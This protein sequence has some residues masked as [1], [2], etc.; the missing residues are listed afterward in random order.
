MARRLHS[1]LRPQSVVLVGATERSNWSN[2]VVGNLRTCGYSGQLFLVNPRGGTAYGLPVHRMV[3]EIQEPVDLAYL[4]VP[5]AAM[6]EAL[7]DLAAAGIT[8]AIVLTSGFAE[9]GEEGAR[10]QEALRDK[11]NAHGVSLIGPNCLGFINQVDNIPLW[12]IALPSPMIRGTLAIVSQSGATAALMSFFAAQQGIGFSHLVSTGNEVDVDIAAVVDYLVDDPDTRAIALFVET[13][14]HPRLL[15]AAAERAHAAKKPIIVMKIGASEIT[16]KSAQAHTG[17]LV[18]DDRVFD[19][20]CKK[21]GLIRVQSIEDAIFTAETITKLGVI[22]GKLGFASMSGGFCEIAADRAHGEGVP[23]ATLAAGTVGRLKN[24][25]PGFGTPHNPLDTTGAVMLDPSIM[26]RSLDALADDPEVGVIAV[27]YDVPTNEGED[28]PFRRAVVTEV[29]DT[30]HRS[31]LPSVLFSYTM[32]PIND[33]ARALLGT[34]GPQA[35][36][37]ACGAHHGLTALRG[38]FGWSD[39]IRRPRVAP[40]EVARSR[41]RPVTEHQTLD[42]LA[43]AGVPVI[44]R[45]VADSA[46]SA[47]DAAGRCGYPVVLK[48]ASADIP[49]KTE[50]GGVALCL[51]DA[52]AVRTAHATI[53]Q[54]VTAARPDARLD[55]VLVA[56]MRE[57]GIELFVGTLRDPQWGAVLAVGLGG[58]FVEVLKDTS[59][60]L[61]PVT[62]AA[63][64]EMLAELRGSALLD[65]FRGSLPADRQRI[66]EVVAAIGNAALALGPELVSLEVNPLRV[67]GGDCEA[68]DALAVWDVP[69]QLH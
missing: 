2:A 16:A 49:H 68:L 59:L 15:A 31:R 52:A 12:S 42:Y 58:V 34:A 29:L 6:D 5:V 13:V 48:I 33:F 23:L 61:L 62:P 57:A 47:I 44:P 45:T 30:M 20:A 51:R 55:G 60:R 21:L 41:A 7:A 26:S 8:Q 10:Q 67:H 66:A 63:V 65:G 27:S 28:N 56:P 18:G 19:A 38:A 35:H 36:Y 43:S 32:R 3:R 17:A 54:R 11:A 53:L 22:D 46:E 64:L 39:H 24:I 40:M 4:M 37:I 50:V 69:P 25:L 9:A 1:F 14:R